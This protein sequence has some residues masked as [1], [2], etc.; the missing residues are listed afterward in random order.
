MNET[1]EFI[2]IIRPEFMRICKDACRAAALNHLLFRI[3]YKCKDQPKEK[4][5]AG[6]ITW[7]ARTE[8]IVEEMSHAWGE[9]KVR[10][11][12]NALISDGLIG[13]KNNPHFGADRTKHFSFGH[14]Q[15]QKFLQLCTEQHICVVHLDLPTEVKHLIYISNANDTSIKCI[16]LMHQ[17]ETIDI[18]NAND[19]SITA[20]TK[21]DYKD[22]NKE[23]SVREKDCAQSP[24]S[25]DAIALATPSPVFVPEE[26]EK[27]RPTITPSQ[28]SAQ[29]SHLPQASDMT[30]NEK[31]QP[32]N[33]VQQT[34]VT[35]AST[36]AKPAHKPKVAKEGVSSPERIEAVFVCMD[37]TI[38][39]LTKQEDFTFGRTKKAREAIRD[40]LSGRSVSPE[41]LDW[42]ITRLWNKPKDERSGFYWRENLS[43]VAICNNYDREIVN[44]KPPLHV[45][46]PPTTPTEPPVD[47]SKIF[48]MKP[49]F[50]RAPKPPLRRFAQ[51]QAQKAEVAP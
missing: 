34:K 14:D 12:V 42:H 39:R 33:L 6:D 48:S 32:A 35:Q 46:P 28:P 36:A 27:E 9:C 22:T 16:C 31:E 15:C 4:V 25:Q 19:I 51:A 17:M 8:Q 50:H 49:L 23:E 47:K 45:V 11:E 40:L 29:T 5:Q 18:S 13:R 21:K 41:K 26:K 38:R 24:L 37:T 3:A 2:T 44:Y 30:P 1:T 20:I 10:K 7:Y 43:V